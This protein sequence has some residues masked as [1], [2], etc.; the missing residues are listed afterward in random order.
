VTDYFQIDGV[1]LE[2]ARWF[3]PGAL[4]PILLLHEG[5]GSV[6]MWHDFPQRLA[7]A[8]GRTVIAWSRQG[9]GQSD[10]RCAPNEPGYMHREASL[11]PKL[12]DALGVEHVHLF[13]HSDGA[14]IALLAAADDSGER[15]QSLILA[16]PHVLVEQVTIDG[17]A[18]I[19]ERYAE[20]APKLGRYHRDPAHVF[21]GWNDIWLD[22][23]FR[24]WNIETVLPRVTVPVLLIQGIDDEYGT[25]DQ[26][27]RIER[28][29][30][31]PVTRLELA[32]CGHSPHREQTDA[33][34]DAA[35]RFL[36]D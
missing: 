9:Y 14:S 16:A 5:L 7:A 6:A 3:Q 20:L 28:S 12:F 31:G 26:L 36:A 30:R 23:R 35:R 13:G 10:P 19:R 34:L 29:A 33:V 4:H 17:I 27:D 21:T 8:S 25:M 11:L 15:I 18:A 22:P 32:A 24:D 1:R 2:V